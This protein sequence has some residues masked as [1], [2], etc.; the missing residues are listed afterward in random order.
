MTDSSG[1][2]VWAADYK[3]FGEA[4]ITV[5]TITNNLRFPGQYFDAETGLHQNGYRDYNLNGRYIEADPIASGIIKLFRSEPQINI[6][7]FRPG[8]PN[9]LN[10]Y[11]YASNNSLR[12]TDPLGLDSEPE[13]C[14]KTRYRACKDMS[15]CQKWICKKSIDWECKRSFGAKGCCDVTYKGCLACADKAADTT[16]KTIAT[17]MCAAALAKCIAGTE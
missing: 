17:E 9:D 5:S 4:T 13:D 3:P 7:L 11:A 10:L 8:L 16:L 14:T 15:W 6:R 2:V 1:T 12:F